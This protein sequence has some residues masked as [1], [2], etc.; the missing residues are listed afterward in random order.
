MRTLK[1]KHLTLEDRYVI[2]E[3][4]S[5]GYSSTQ[6][7][8]RLN[9]SRRTIA[10]EVLKHRILKNTSNVDCKKVSSFPY[11][12]DN[13]PTSRRCSC[14]QYRYDARI[15]HTEYQKTLKETR[16]FVHV[17]KSEVAAINDVIAP[18]MV[19]Q[20]HSVNQV[21]IEH[22]EVL[23][24][25]K[26][27]FY[28]YIDM[29]LLNV[30]NIDLQRKVRFKVK[31]EKNDH[32]K[33]DDRTYRQG[34]KYEDFKDYMDIFPLASIVEMDTVVGTSGGK[35]GKCMLT[36]L[37]RQYNFMLIFLLPYKR[38]EFV[39]KVFLSLQELLGEK[40]YSRLFQVVLT[41]NG[42]EFTDPETI[43][44]SLFTGERI[45]NV[46]YCD[47]NSSW[48]KGQLEKNHEYIRYVLPKGTSFAGLSQDDCNTLAS[49]INS[50][51]R[52]V[53]NNCCPYEMAIKFIGEKNMDKLNISRIPND[54]INLSIRLLKK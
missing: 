25:S 24:F 15:A 35:G 23:P 49:H 3:Y 39:N 21:Y 44:Y 53:L 22:P 20:N 51:P 28:R 18:L 13:C 42:S 6:I 27:T 2:Q 12:C 29:G 45:S 38:K 17:N 30:R 7:G 14:R 26:S 54:D 34:R 47:P 33:I 1:H 36:L 9:K 4:L 48:Q 43:E 46:F 41:D 32:S 19:H 11:V 52:V 40:E 5:H 50:V 16:S 37:W 8:N 31:K 10:K